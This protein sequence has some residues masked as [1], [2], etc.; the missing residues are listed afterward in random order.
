MFFLIICL[1]D[2]VHWSEIALRQSVFISLRSYDL[3][4]DSVT[5]VLKPDLDMKMY[6]HTIH[7]VSV[8]SRS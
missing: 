7:E 4:L 6:R 1:S 3:D 2:E 8:L 5:L